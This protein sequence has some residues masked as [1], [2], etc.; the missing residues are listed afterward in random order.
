MVNSNATAVQAIKTAAA[1]YGL[2]PQAM[3]AV[4]RVESGLNPKAIGDGGHAFGLFQFNNAG[5]VITGQAN[6][7]RYLDPAY[8]AMEAARHIASIKGAR[9]VRGADAVKLIVNSFERPANK[10]AEISKALSYLGQGTVTA[11][12]INSNAPQTA[13]NG[14]SAQSNTGGQTT[15]S[16]SLASLLSYTMQ[17]S[18]PSHSGAGTSGDIL[19]VLLQQGQ[20]S[21]APTIGQAPANSAVAGTSTLPTSVTPTAGTT[22][23]V[24]SKDGGNPKAKVSGNYGAVTTIKDPTLIGL[25][26][27][28]THRQYNNWESDNAIDIKMPDNT[29]IYAAADG[30]IGPQFGDLHS[31]D[32]HMKGQRMHLVTNGNEFYYQHMKTITVK[33]GEKVT[34]GQLIGYSGALNHL[35]L[36]VKNGSPLAYK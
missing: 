18:A 31:K 17:G 5:G 13:P 29:P 11:P 22:S 9:N 12:T 34:K 33:P 26:Y 35:H 7:E 2:D 30:T 23:P 15:G 10:G 20:D 1:K 36:G 4:A 28:G 21:T 3:I 32:P 27:Q 8:N 14:L 24:Y 25:P 16:N 19:N 6:P